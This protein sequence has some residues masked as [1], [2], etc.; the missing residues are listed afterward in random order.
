MTRSTRRASSFRS[1][2]GPAFRRSFERPFRNGRIWGPRLR[3]TSQMYDAPDFKPDIS[4]L[5]NSRNYQFCCNARNIFIVNSPSWRCALHLSDGAGCLGSSSCLVFRSGPGANFVRR[6]DYHRYDE[7]CHAEN[8][9][10]HAEHADLLCQRDLA[11]AGRVV[12]Q[13]HD[14]SPARRLVEDL[15]RRADLHLQPQKRSKVERRASPDVRRCPL[16]REPDSH[17][18]L[19]LGSRHL[20]TAARLEQQQSFR[21]STCSGCCDRS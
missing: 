2:V 18:V 20:R 19:V 14:D 13:R 6:Y 3:R 12:L 17:P 7:R 9:Q 5:E 21:R 8:F 15:V 4:H 1:S 10:R 11:G 16:L